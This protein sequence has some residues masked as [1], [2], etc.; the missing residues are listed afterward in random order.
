MDVLQA[1]DVIVSSIGVIYAEDK[2][3]LIK[4]LQ[5]AGLKIDANASEKN[6]LGA[7]IEAV[8]DS[9]S[10]RNDLKKY[11]SFYAKE[12]EYNNYVDD[13]FFNQSSASLGL[14]TRAERL[15][16]LTPT[17]SA[18]AS[19]TSSKKK[20][21]GGTAVG[22]FL[23][24]VFTRENIDTAINTGVNFYSTKLQQ[25]ANR[26]GEQRAIDFEIAKARAAAEQA[27]AAEAQSLLPRKN[28]WVAPVLIVT[29]LLVVGTVIYFVVRKKA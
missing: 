11:L 2:E 3:S 16:T 7:S 21:E 29:G 13:D 10:F 17:A 4:M 8:K 23:R 25:R 19:A 24:S 20:K 1:N 5:R 9:A 14:P 26:E 12:G 18:T 15:T 22:N 27:R 28:A 6:I